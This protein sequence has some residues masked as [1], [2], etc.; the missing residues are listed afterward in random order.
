MTL[1][2]GGLVRKTFQAMGTTVEMLV[3]SQSAMRA[4]GGV[5]R[6]FA[7]WEETLSRFRPESELSRLNRAAGQ[8]LRA[9]PLLYSVVERALAQAAFTSG[10]FDPTL[11]RQ[12]EQLGYDRTFAEI[13]HGTPAQRDLPEVTPGGGWQGVRL[14]QG[15]MTIR[16]PEGVAIDLGGIAKGM[17][18][19]AAI[20][21]LRGAGISFGL[22]NAGG[23]MRVHGLP[24]GQDSWVVAVS[25]TEPQALVPLRRGAMATSGTSRRRW[26]Q[27]ELERH[28]LL[29]PRSGCPSDAAIRTVTVVAGSCEEADVAAKI[30]F[31]R[32]VEAGSEYLAEHALSGLFVLADG[33]QRAFGRWPGTGGR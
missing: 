11:L 8:T 16:L 9:S 27:G 15:A 24:P 32:G 20:D 28:H 2:A 1:P 33:M 21:W 13:E 12:I 14:D 7:E 23:D 4:L 22:V 3:P 26:L 18:V 31:I 17:A 5:R 29:D 30:A 25:G 6:L 19:D 10:T